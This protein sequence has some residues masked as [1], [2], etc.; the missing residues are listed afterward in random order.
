MVDPEWIH[1]HIGGRL[2]TTELPWTARWVMFPLVE[3]WEQGNV[4]VS[5]PAA[6]VCADP[7]GIAATEHPHSAELSEQN[8][9][10]TSAVAFSLVANNLEET[11]ETGMRV[12]CGCTKHGFR[13]AKHHMTLW[14]LERPDQI[15]IAG[16]VWKAGNYFSVLGLNVV[17]GGPLEYE[18]RVGK[19]WSALH[20]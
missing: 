1:V 6:E 10:S 4:G 16:R 20:A 14:T 11:S 7:L 8:M 18:R 2:G 12:P 15:T 17:T 9:H 5:V 13:I 3:K 19:A